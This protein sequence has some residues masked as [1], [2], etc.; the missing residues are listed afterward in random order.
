M[1]DTI[2]N[3]ID[4]LADSLGRQWP[5]L[6]VAQENAGDVR[7]AIQSKLTDELGKLDS[8]VD[9]VVFG[10]LAE[11]SRRSEA[12]WIGHFLLTVKRIPSISNSHDRLVLRCQTLSI[13]ERSCPSREEQE[14]LARWCSV[15][16]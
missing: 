10:S 2:R 9:V 4:S 6:A 13:E 7:T 11:G 3:D 1:S 15:M 16:T 5:A 12:M 14:S 8:D